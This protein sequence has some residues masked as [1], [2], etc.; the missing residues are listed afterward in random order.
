MTKSSWRQRINFSRQYPSLF[1]GSETSNLIRN[2]IQAPI[3]LLFGTQAFNNVRSA[4]LNVSP[5]QYRWVSECD[6]LRSEICDQIDWGGCD[7]LFE[8]ISDSWHG[9]R[10]MNGKWTLPFKSNTNPLS[11]FSSNLWFA[12]EGILAVRTQEKIWWQVYHFGW[13]VTPLIEAE[14]INSNV[15][16][17]IAASLTEEWF[18]EL[19]FTLDKVEH[20]ILEQHR[21]QVQV[22][23]ANE[24]NILPDS[25]RFQQ[26]KLGDFLR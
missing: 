21:P 19:P 26:H 10:K 23:W 17:V 16:F 24:D 6:G 4:V 9:V 8:A 18:K 1:L 13:P 20:G 14:N 3:K 25:I 7:V 15:G 5:R 22:K 12:E 11:W 2:S